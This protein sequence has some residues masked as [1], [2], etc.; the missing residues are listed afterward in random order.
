MRIAHVVNTFPPYWSG[1][2]VAALNQVKALSRRGHD[3]HV[4]TP[5]MQDARHDD[6]IGVE[7]HRQST[8]FRLGMAPLTPGL[9]GLR[10]FEIIHLH[11]P[12]YFG[13]ELASLA[14]A[15]RRIPIVITYHNDVV[16]PDLL[17]LVVEAH[18]RSLA[19]LVLARAA[20]VCVMSETF[21]GRSALLKRIERAGNVVIVPHGVD[22]IRFRSMASWPQAFDLLGLSKGIPILLFVRMLDDAHH[23][24]GLGFLV[25]AMCNIDETA[26]L[27]IVGDGALRPYYEELVRGFALQDRVHFAGSVPNMELPSIYAASSVFVLPSSHT[28]SA[29]LVLLEALAS[30]VPVVATDVGGARDQFQ[31]RREG[32]LVPSRDPGSLANAINSLLRDQEQARS[33]GE[34]GSRR[35]RETRNWERIAAKLESI[36]EDV[37]CESA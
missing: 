18:D 9:L 27:V 11:F 23:H 12:Y 3:V 1:T 32:L 5:Q 31:H 33:M 21:L 29:G 8:L 17:A 26:H 7:V 36:Y 25:R 16:K 19:P 28:E 10:D 22:I 37:L 4:F 13:A 30:A 35:I 2:G 34:A 15:V 20:R 14:S 24:S 6:T